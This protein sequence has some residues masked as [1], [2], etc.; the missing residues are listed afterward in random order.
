MSLGKF[1]SFKYYLCMT[2]SK[3][4]AIV[5]KR[6]W[7]LTPKAKPFAALSS[8][9]G[10]G[11][12]V[13]LGMSLFSV[14]GNA[15]LLRFTSVITW[16]L[17][18]LSLPVLTAI[19][20]AIIAKRLTQRYL[21]SSLEEG[22][23]AAAGAGLASFL[24]G[25]GTITLLPS[26]FLQ[27]GFFAPLAVGV[28]TAAGFIGHQAFSPLRSLKDDQT[29]TPALYLSSISAGVSAIHLTFWSGL[30]SIFLGLF[31]PGM[32]GFLEHLLNN[33]FGALIGTAMCFGA[34]A[35]VTLFS[36][37][38]LAKK[39]SK[40]SRAFLALGVGLPLLVPGL[41]SLSILFE[42]AYSASLA[43]VWLFSSMGLALGSLPHLLGIHL[44]LGLVDRQEK[45]NIEKKEKLAIEATS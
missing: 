7:A 20:A 44:G 45:L 31:Y 33:P 35:P 37:R 34:L 28:T 29:E 21:R 3:S 13:V 43:K 40:G 1:F 4:L 10:T 8:G 17:A 14:L 6:K 15:G 18:S 42:T 32:G 38:F 36:T 2:A 27:L 23:A 11:S 5:P 16:F 25:L 26:N 39:Y 41:V 12:A 9:L 30:L 19:P 24:V 22:Q